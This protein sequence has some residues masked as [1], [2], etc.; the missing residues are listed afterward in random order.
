MLTSFM[1]DF[2]TFVFDLTPFSEGNVFRSYLHIFNLT[3]GAALL[4]YLTVQMFQ[5]LH[6]RI[7]RYPKNGASK[8]VVHL[9]KHA[10]FHLY[11]VHPDGII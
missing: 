8:S 5:D 4:S 2:Q 1:F 11:R 10:N 9:I 3:K 7:D 6:F